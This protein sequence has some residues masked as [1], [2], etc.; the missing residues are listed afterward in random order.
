MRLHIAIALTALSLAGVSSEYAEG[1]LI[2]GWLSG[3]SY[4]DIQPGHAPARSSVEPVE[5]EVL[6]EEGRRRTDKKTKVEVSVHPSHEQSG[7]GSDLGQI[8]PIVSLP[9]PAPLPLPAPLPP[10]GGGGLKPTGGSIGGGGLGGLGLGLKPGGGGILGHGG[11]EGGGSQPGWG[12]GWISDIM[13][14]PSWGSGW[15]GLFPGQGISG[16]PGTGIGNKPS[17]GSY[18]GNKGRPSGTGHHEDNDGI[19]SVSYGKPPPEHYDTHGPGIF[20][21]FAGWLYP[22]PGYGNPKG[23]VPSQTL[24]SPTTSEVLVVRYP[25]F[26]KTIGKGI[27]QMTNAVKNL[28][29]GFSES[30]TKG[31]HDASAGIGSGVYS[32]IP[33]EE[34]GNEYQDKGNQNYPNKG[35]FGGPLGG[36]GLGGGF[37]GKPGLGGAGGKPGLGHGGSSGPVSTVYFDKHPS[38][39][40]GGFGS[41]FPKPSSWFSSAYIDPDTTSTVYV[42]KG[43]SG[44]GN[45]GSSGLSH[46]G[47]H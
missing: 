32:I 17:G 4:P 43:S 37:G 46:K 10:I 7:I 45:K 1:R 2:S 31:I 24:D 36:L 3:E 12:W 9:V 35:G 26:I 13:K 22:D 23:G 33:L 11:A 18:F 27:S 28:G 15:S 14:G 38:V 41:W 19:V 42:D 39:P 21:P 6:Q 5:K 20:N 30:I 40:A 29:E 47:H 16:G 25:E 44:L 34:V 8:T